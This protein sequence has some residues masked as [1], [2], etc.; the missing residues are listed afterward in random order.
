MGY[1]D[2]FVRQEVT[3]FALNKRTLSG[4]WQDMCVCPVMGVHDAVKHA[5]TQS[6]LIDLIANE[7]RN[8]LSRVQTS[9][10][11]ASSAQG[12]AIREVLMNHQRAPNGISHP[13]SPANPRF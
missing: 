5:T 3:D 10:N 13:P 11:E 1:P 7:L 2:G 12:R 8:V 9:L 6:G 4:K